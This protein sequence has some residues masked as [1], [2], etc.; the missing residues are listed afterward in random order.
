MKDE[1]IIRLERASREKIFLLEKSL[2][3]HR[4]IFNICGTTK[5][6]YNI[7]VYFGS[8][9]IFCN[10]PDGRGQ[11][12][13][14]GV[15]C[16]HICFLI[17][18]VFSKLFEYTSIY[19]ILLFNKDEITKIQEFVE[20]E[21][22]FDESCMDQNVLQK[23]LSTKKSLESDEPK[24][25]LEMLKDIECPIC[26]DE[27]EN[28]DVLTCNVCNKSFHTHCINIWLQTSHNKSCPYCRSIIKKPNSG[29]YIN[30]E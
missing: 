2:E 30:L 27:F 6:V 13:R 14:I 29:Y 15:F 16:K 1:Q 26:Y 23:F 17:T 28:T 25:T 5:N 11:C 22:Q 4:C 19:D 24:I 7:S 21:L 9:K 18:K 12:K 3:A 10:C 8:G 20:K